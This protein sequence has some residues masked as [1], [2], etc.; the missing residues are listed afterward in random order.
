M[1]FDIEQTNTS[2]KPLFPE[3]INTGHVEELSSLDLFKNSLP[4]Y[5]EYVGDPEPEPTK[6]NPRYIAKTLVKITEVEG[7]I[8]VKKAC[9]I[10]LRKLE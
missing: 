9:D 5:Q 10:Y 7:P 2:N 3:N 1:V 8:L 6:T 4:I